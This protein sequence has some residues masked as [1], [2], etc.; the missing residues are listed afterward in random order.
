MKLI[1]GLFTKKQQTVSKSKIVLK[2]DVSH[3]LNKQVLEYL[4]RS[5]AKYKPLINYPYEV[6][7]PYNNQGSHPEIVE[8]V[9][10]DINSKLPKDCRCLIYGTPA[11]V[12]SD[13]GII[14][15]ICC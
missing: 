14:L 5:S 9:W 8:R 4:D 3:P 15:A 7:D 2:V 13:T 10:D 1:K 6:K 11:L 12:H